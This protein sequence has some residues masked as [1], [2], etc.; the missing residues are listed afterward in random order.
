MKGKKIGIIV[1]AVLFAAL[2]CVF[3][4]ING[5]WNEDEGDGTGDDV[6]SYTVSKIESSSIKS[7]SYTN[8][9]KEYSFTL[10]GSEWKYDKDEKFPLDTQSVTEF[11]EALS[12]IT[13]DKM[14]EGKATDSAEYGLDVP[15]HVVR[16]G[17]D[18]GSV[19]TYHIGDYNRHSGLYYLSYD[20]SD[21]IYM[22]QS[23]F[24]SAFTLEEEDLLVLETMDSITA[25]SVTKIVSDS[26]KGIITLEVTEED[27]KKIYTHTN[28][29][30][31][32]QT[33]DAEGAEKMIK[34]LCSPSLK[35]CFDYYAEDAE[36]EEYGLAQAQGQRA[37]ITV[38]YTSKITS[39]DQATGA[40][41]TSTMKRECV[42]YIVA[43]PIEVEGE[44]G[45][46]G[47]NSSDTSADTTENSS[48]KNEE[49][50]KNESKNL[51]MLED[52]RMIFKVNISG[53]D[54]FFD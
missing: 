22:V 42:Y 6:K 52:S 24:A 23:S 7:I 46:N 49:T 27:E 35:D 45:E 30:G 9:G 3:L 8:N 18:D 51:L 38:S 29:Q 44:D 50:S 20:K 47:D 19:H 21:K 54:A 28:A 17:C 15:S 11:A 13:A 12:D 2:L 43:A 1:M 34:A 36:L 32:V 40:Q 5:R 48:E 41:N 53:A 10:E 33:L 31:G 26:P 16:V 25:D 4:L 14:I 39:T 37:K